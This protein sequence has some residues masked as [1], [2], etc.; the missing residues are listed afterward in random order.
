MNGKRLGILAV[1]LLLATA[2]RT[3]DAAVT[4]LVKAKLA[5][6]LTVPAYRIDVDTTNGVVT[7]T[8]N[9][10]DIVAKERA[11]Q[12][13][14]E[15]RGVK[16]VVDMIAIRRPD[17]TGDAPSPGRTIGTALD[18]SGITLE[19]KGRLISDP[20]VEARH[21]DVDTRDGVVYLTGTVHTPKERDRAVELARNTK[22]VRD[23]QAN[24]AVQES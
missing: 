21:I 7:L 8:G 16:Q 15:T 14:Q 18:D 3:S 24:L 13:A 23:V 19:V 6:D 11:L 12:T 9:L 2:C 10:D 17:G 1:A 4:G 20:L 22:G 5:A